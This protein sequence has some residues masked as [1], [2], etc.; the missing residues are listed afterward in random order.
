MT[1]FPKGTEMRSLAAAGMVRKC[2]GVAAI[3]QPDAHGNMFH[4]SARA[5]DGSINNRHRP[6]GRLLD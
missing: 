1:L 6:R 3:Q 2:V 5:S 4:Y